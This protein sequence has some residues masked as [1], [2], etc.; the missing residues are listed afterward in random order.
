MFRCYTRPAAMSHCGA[1]VEV[2]ALRANMAMNCGYCSP[3]LEQPNVYKCA[4]YVSE[5]K[6]RHMGSDFEI[7]DKGCTAARTHGPKLGSQ[8]CFYHLLIRLSYSE[9]AK[10][11]R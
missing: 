3:D 9:F 10:E 6:V 2:M 4:V 5:R 8:K 7:T 11:R 1:P